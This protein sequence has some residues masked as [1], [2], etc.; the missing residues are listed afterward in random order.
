MFEDEKDDKI[1][2]LIISNGT[3]WC[4]TA[5]RRSKYRSAG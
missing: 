3:F 4:Y 5:L 1:Y 2:N